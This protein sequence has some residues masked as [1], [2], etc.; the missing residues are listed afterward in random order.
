MLPLQSLG[1]MMIT[2]RIPGLYEGHPRDP[3][4]VIPGLY[5]D[6]PRDTLTQVYDDHVR[7]LW[8]V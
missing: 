2:R 5:E 3:W 4:G 7:E 1:C 8:G 6:H